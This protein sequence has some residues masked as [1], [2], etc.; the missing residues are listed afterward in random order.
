[1]LGRTFAFVASLSLALAG[2]SGLAWAEGEANLDTLSQ[3]S[4]VGTEAE[5]RL[6]TL[7]EVN[8]AIETLATG[9]LELDGLEG[10]QNLNSLTQGLGGN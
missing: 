6:F 1:M 2:A 9:D 8:T 7:T 10:L 5:E 4:A 3:G